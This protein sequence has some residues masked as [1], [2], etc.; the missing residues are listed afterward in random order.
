MEELSLLRGQGEETGVK[1]RITE[2]LWRHFVA[3]VA[4]L[5]LLI[6]AFTYLEDC[7]GP[8]IRADGAGYYAYLPSWF[9]H[10]DMTFIKLAD[11]Q[12]QGSIPAWTGLTPS[13]ATGGFRNK[14]NIGVAVM[15]TPF[16]FAGHVLTWWMRSPPG[17]FEWW[18]FNHPLDGY[19]LFY[20]HAAGL[21]GVFYMVVGLAVLRSLLATRFTKGVVLSTMATL[22]LGT[23]LLHYGSGETVFSSA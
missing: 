16:F 10:G 5:C 2:W 23:N 21:A 12:F 17:G 13:A 6:Y 20:Q 1:D 3:L 9:I 8:P 22:L 7:F 19:S 4:I 11:A 18:K 15:M 14:Y